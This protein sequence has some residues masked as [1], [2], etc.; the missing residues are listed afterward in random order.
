MFAINA[1]PLIFLAA[2]LSLGLVAGWFA[3]LLGIGAGL[4]MVPVLDELLLHRGFDPDLCLRLSLGTSMAAILVNSLMSA[5]THHQHGAVLWKAVWGLAPGILVGT[6]LGTLAVRAMPTRVLVL[7][8]AGFMIF[9]A[10]QMALNKRPGAHRPLPGTG[11]LL[12]VGSFIGG[13]SSLAAVGGGMLTVPFMLWCGVSIHQAI[14]TA[15]AV[16]FPVALGGSIGY[17]ING[18]DVSG[19]PSGSLGFVY[20]PALLV[21]LA[22][23]VATAGLGARMA[24]RMPVANLKRVFAGFV[25][26]L[27]ARMLYRLFA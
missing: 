7:F 11:G 18:W 17:V 27:A 5:R 6:F 25:T 8:F 16:G 12:A 4:L 1:E 24:H 13:I 2:Y 15:A 22:G 23:S 3:G 26:L 9:V 19:L 14:G 20:L 21:M 10:L